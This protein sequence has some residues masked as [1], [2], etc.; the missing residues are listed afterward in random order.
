MLL[1][2]YKELSFHPYSTVMWALTV[3][4]IHMFKYV[5]LVPALR[6]GMQQNV[7]LHAYYWSLV[8]LLA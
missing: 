3:L 4:D 2:Y 7:R 1:A 6:A 8:T 5:Y